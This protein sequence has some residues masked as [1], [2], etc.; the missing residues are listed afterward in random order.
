MP[1]DHGGAM[2]TTYVRREFFAN[3]G[4]LLDAGILSDLSHTGVTW[5]Q[6]DSPQST[7]GQARLKTLTVW[8]AANADSRAAGLQACLARIQST[9]SSVAA[10]VQVL[11]QE[12][13]AKGV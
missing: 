12:Q 3:I 1:P 10:W 4:T 5:A 2:A 11:P 7:A 8:I 9:D 13:T 6:Q